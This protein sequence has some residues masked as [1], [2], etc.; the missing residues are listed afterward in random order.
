MSLFAKGRTSRQPRLIALPDQLLYEILSFLDLRSINNLQLLNKALHKK[1]TTNL[2]QKLAISH[3]RYQ[4]NRADQ[5]SYHKVYRNLWF[6]RHPR[7][8]KQWIADMRQKQEKRMLV[9]KN[10]VTWMRYFQIVILFGNI[11]AYMTSIIT[12]LAC[13][14]LY[15]LSSACITFGDDEAF[16]QVVESGFPFS[17]IWGNQFV[18]YGFLAIYR[19]KYGFRLKSIT[20]NFE[21]SKTDSAILWDQF[22]VYIFMGVWLLISLGDVVSWNNYLI[23]GSLGNCTVELTLAPSFA[24][25]V[26][27]CYLAWIVF[28]LGEWLLLHMINRTKYLALHE[29]LLV[30]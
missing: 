13:G 27:G 19:V 2:W 7:Q 5:E 4:G 14:G 8:Q 6:E 15:Q 28:L 18:W 29:A 11:T 25:V 1:F 24:Y 10:Q 12:E 17:L 23:A 3:F 9:L 22:G 16:V 26:P 21:V 30:L 20:W